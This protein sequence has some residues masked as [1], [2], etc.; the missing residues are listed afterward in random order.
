MPSADA[1]DFGAGHRLVVGDDRQGFGRGAGQFAGDFGID[2]QMVGQI[3]G[4][5]EPPAAAG[6]DQIDAA[7]EKSGPGSLEKLINSGD[8][9]IVE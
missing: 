6:T 3:G 7:I 1:F 9:W 5:A 4:G 8:T 2:A